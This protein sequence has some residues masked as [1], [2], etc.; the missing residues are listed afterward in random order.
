MKVV[1]N[2]QKAAL[3]ILADAQASGMKRAEA[4]FVL[5]TLL[6]ATKRHLENRREALDHF[7]SAVELQPENHRFQHFLSAE[8][9]TV[10]D[11]G[12]ALRHAK[13][14]QHLAPVDRRATYD[15]DIARCYTNL[16]MRVH[17]GRVK[18][19]FEND[20]LLHF[21][22]FIGVNS[23]GSA[24]P[25]LS[26]DPGE[27]HQNPCGLCNK[28]SNQSISLGCNHSFC[29]ICIES[30]CEAA[31]HHSNDAT[32]PVC[33]KV[34][35]SADV[36]MI[37]AANQATR[38]RRLE[39]GDPHRG[40]LCGALTQLAHLEFNAAARGSQI[41]EEAYAR[42]A[43]HLDR[44]EQMNPF[45]AGRQQRHGAAHL[46]LA[47]STKIMADEMRRDQSHWQFGIGDV[48]EISGLQTGTQYN[49]EFAVVEKLHPTRPGKLM[50][51]VP[52]LLHTISVASTKVALVH[53]AAVS[54]ASTS[55]STLVAVV[56]SR[57]RDKHNT[58][59]SIL[60]SEPRPFACFSGMTGCFCGR[61]IHGRRS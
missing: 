18:I 60:A 31:R 44:A 33:E 42:G 26:G 23:D 4:H 15:Y 58:A 36:S 40:H 53:S 43:E 28:V 59:S 24:P 22:A 21:R 10:G 54:P 57:G 19:G 37:A 9:A 41:D 12:L 5:A 55:H 25:Q 20:A 32:C 56:H 27:T 30:H 16:C 11:Y 13:A 2:L 50:L 29:E 35:C 52:A 45:L 7:R 46:M 48:V 51:K 1:S 39:L 61:R 8:H 49:G 6:S 3:G 34:V 38:L 47:Q 14:A 17:C